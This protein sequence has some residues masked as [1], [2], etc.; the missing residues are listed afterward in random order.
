MS[1]RADGGSAFPYS[2]LSPD[3]LHMYADSRGMSLRDYF[4]AAYISGLSGREMGLSFEE[5][6]A[7]A[8]DCADAML[9][10]RAK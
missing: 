7:Y 8:Y 2:A 9:N 4:A 6:A 1:E 3:G 10:A 5:V